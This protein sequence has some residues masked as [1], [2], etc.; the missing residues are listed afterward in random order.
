MSSTHFDTKFMYVK[1]MLNMLLLLLN[2]HVWIV[3]I[4]YFVDFCS[5]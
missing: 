1:L 2:L 5:I 4:L 3:V